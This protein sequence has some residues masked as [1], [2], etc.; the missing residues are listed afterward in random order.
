VKILSVSELPEKRSLY[1]IPSRLP[2]PISSSPFTDI[3]TY[4]SR[5][6]KAREEVALYTLQLK[7]LHQKYIGMDDMTPRG[8]IQ[9]QISETYL[10]LQKAQLAVAMA[11]MELDEARKNHKTKNQR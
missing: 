3:N 10:K 2:L 9:K 7:A 6:Q 4:E 1:D 11:K 8:L 5:W